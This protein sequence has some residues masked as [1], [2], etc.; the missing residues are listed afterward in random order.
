MEDSLLIRNL[1]KALLTNTLKKANKE[2]FD[3]LVDAIVDTTNCSMC[4][5]WSINNSTREKKENEGTFQSISIISRNLKGEIYDSDNVVLPLH[6]TFIEKTIENKKPYYMGYRSDHRL[7][8]YIKKFNLNFFIGIPIPDFSNP[9]KTIA[10]LKLSYI[11]YQEIDQ[12]EIELF[13]NLIRSYISSSLNRNIEL[14]K[15]EVMEYLVKNYQDKGTEKNIK[16]IFN[17]IIKT[18]LRKYCDYEGAS[19]FMWDS[20]VNQYKLISTTGIIETINENDYQNIYYQAGE[21]L[22]GKVA[23]E[24]KSIIYDKLNDEEQNVPEYKHKFIETTTHIGT[25]MLV[26]P[27]FRP[28]KKDE[29]IGILRFVNK[30]NPVNSDVVDFFNDTD[31]EIISYVSKY[32]ALIID[33]F[34]AE[35]ERNDFISKLS[36]EFS[37]PA[38]AIRV[39]AD[40]LLKLGN[41][42]TYIKRYFKSYVESIWYFAEL[43]LQRTTT[44]LFVSK[45]RRNIPKFQKYNSSW[46]SIKDMISKSKIVVTPIAREEGLRFDNI[47]I[48]ENFPS[49][50]LFV[51]EFAFT[52]IFYNL[53]TNAMKYRNTNLDFYVTITGYETDENLIINVSDYGLGIE[54]KDKENIFLLGF[55]GENVTKRNANGLGIGLHVIKQIINDFGGEISVTNLKSPTKFEIKLPKYLLTDSYT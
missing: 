25:T 9:I 43:Q 30:K 40:R 53:L 5:L 12:K 32:L 2:M 10:V 55:R 33:Y 35:E 45:N 48:D 20:Y 19:F 7:Q 8:D 15:L 44:N 14:K 6:G 51:D 54:K 21:G 36:H 28:S 50:L 22:T 52:S 47:Q 18:I 11:D 17:P 29:I 13:A 38:N 24:K 34:L 49:W 41:D 16:N 26:V 3:N 23:Y 31:E 46:T 1:Q 37:A 42:E 4:S 39:T 27:I